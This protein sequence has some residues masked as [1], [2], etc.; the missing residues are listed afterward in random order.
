[1]NTLR[2]S[3][4][5]TE[6]KIERTVLSV[7]RCVNYDRAEFSFDESWTGFTKTAAGYAFLQRDDT[8]TAG[9]CTFIQQFGVEWRGKPC[10]D[11]AQL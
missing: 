11:H 6:L 4:C 2:L 1:M 7:E 8:A 3:V 9:S 5:K 10:I